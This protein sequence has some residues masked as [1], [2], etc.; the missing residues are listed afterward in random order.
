MARGTAEHLINRRLGELA[1][2]IERGHI[3]A[4]LR[5][6]GAGELHLHGFV[7]RCRT[8]SHHAPGGFDF[9]SRY[10]AALPETHKARLRLQ[11]EHAISAARRRFVQLPRIE[12]RDIEICHAL[13][14]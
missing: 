1:Y 14:P 13:L 10:C 12:R 5:A 8:A 7:R 3:D 9:R 6:W 2:E 11:A 4:R